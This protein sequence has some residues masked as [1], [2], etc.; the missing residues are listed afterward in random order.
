MESDGDNKYD[1]FSVSKKGAQNL[2]LHLCNKPVLI[3]RAVDHRLKTWYNMLIAVLTQKR[4]QKLKNISIELSTKAA[5]TKNK[6]I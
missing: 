3:F 4:A 5:Q 1:L 6:K 2:C